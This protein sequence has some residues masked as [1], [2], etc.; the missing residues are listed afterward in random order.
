ME[1]PLQPVAGY[2]VRGLDQE[3]CAE[4]IRAV[5]GLIT[6]STPGIREWTS[7]VFAVISVMSM[8]GP[9]YQNADARVIQFQ[10]QKHHVTQL[11]GHG[12][13]KPGPAHSFSVYRDRFWVH[14]D[15]ISACR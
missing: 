6:Y 8:S 11:I 15:R 13:E 1:R 9:L 10:D 5:Y 4:L 12:A 14:R 2:R 3:I 7:A